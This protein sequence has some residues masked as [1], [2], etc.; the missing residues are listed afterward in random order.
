MKLVNVEVS[1]PSV[2]ETTAPAIAEGGWY[3]KFP[4]GLRITLDASVI[5]KLNLSLDDYTPGTSVKIIAEATVI[6]TLDEKVIDNSNNAP[7]SIEM[8]IT[9]LATE[10]SVEGDFE[11]AFSEATN[12][13]Y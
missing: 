5:D 1:R 2:E 9:E 13:E 3:E 4:Y 11:R 10:P 8:Q 6:K 7:R 12:E